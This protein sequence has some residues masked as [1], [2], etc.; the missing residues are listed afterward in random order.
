MVSPVKPSHVA[1]CF[2]QVN[3][4]AGKQRFGQE[5]KSLRRLDYEILRFLDLLLVDMPVKQEDFPHVYTHLT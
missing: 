1:G 5:T 4:K 3:H 2:L